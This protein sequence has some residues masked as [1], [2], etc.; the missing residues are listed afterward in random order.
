[1]RPVRQSLLP[2]AVIGLTCAAAGGAD[3]KLLQKPAD[4]Y[5]SPR[6]AAGQD[7]VPL[8]TTFYVE[9]APGDAKAADDVLPESVGVELEPEGGPAFPLLRP[10]RQF[11]EGCAGRF[12]PG[13]EDKAGPTLGVYIDPARH[14]PPAMRYTVRVVA[15]TRGGA[16][17]PAAAG[18]WRFTT[19]AEPKVHPLSCYLALAGPA[20]RWQGGFF[21]G[22]CSPGFCTSHTHRIPTYELMARV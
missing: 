6:P 2:V 17:L 21:T 20:V 14:L 13:K 16:A 9:L 8:R 3:V 10:G 5:G 4:P 15:R 19:E 18:T 12:I 7:H 11:A 22:F 1:M